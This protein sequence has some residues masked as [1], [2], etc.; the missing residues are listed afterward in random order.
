M[1]SFISA[2]R[3]KNTSNDPNDVTL[4]QLTIPLLPLRSLIPAAYVEGLKKNR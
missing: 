3:H 1:H 4:T 2:L